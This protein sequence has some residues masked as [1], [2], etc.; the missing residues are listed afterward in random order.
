MLSNPLP[1]RIPK[2]HTISMTKQA[3]KTRV[4]RDARPLRDDSGPSAGVGGRGGRVRY[5]EDGEVQEG[6]RVGGLKGFPRSA[7]VEDF[8][9]A[10]KLARGESAQRDVRVRVIVFVILCLC[11]CVR[12]SRYCARTHI[13]THLV[14]HALLTWSPM[15]RTSIS[16]NAWWRACESLTLVERAD[17]DMAVSKP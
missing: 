11:V 3:I 15:A 9:P 6:S 7:E 2:I 12:A 4:A 14:T 13:V 16:A 10:A 8:S 5:E 1:L 17:S